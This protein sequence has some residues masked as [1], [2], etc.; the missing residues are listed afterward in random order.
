MHNKKRVS[1]ISTA[2]HFPAIQEIS[3]DSTSTGTESSNVSAT[4][5]S[6]SP[7]KELDGQPL[8]QNLQNR[9]KNALT[10]PVVIKINDLDIGKN[11]KVSIIFIYYELYYSFL[12]KSCTHHHLCK[13]TEL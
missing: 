1:T 8:T 3:L 10:N 2:P 5:S 6:E 13:L 4:E 12:R 7:N 11:D 9:R